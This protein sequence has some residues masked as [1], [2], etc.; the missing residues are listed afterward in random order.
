MHM[1]TVLAA[2]KHKI[3]QTMQIVVLMLV[4]MPLEV[5]CTVE[6]YMNAG[7]DAE[8]VMHHYGHRVPPRFPPC[9]HS[10]DDA[11]DGQVDEC[12]QAGAGGGADAAGAGASG[13]DGGCAQA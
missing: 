1:H 7:R 2:N 3:T 12:A 10:Q 4:Q 6:L 13:G 8:T 5:L 11:D 9:A